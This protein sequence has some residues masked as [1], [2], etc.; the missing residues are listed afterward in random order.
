MDSVNVPWFFTMGV[1]SFG[2]PRIEAYLQLPAAYRSLSR[3]SSAP[4]AKA[5]TLCSCS[6]ELPSFESTF[7]STLFSRSYL[8][9][10]SF[11]KTWILQQKGFPS[12]LFCFAS[13]ISQRWQNCFYPFDWKDLISRSLPK[14]R[15]VF[16]LSI[17]FFILNFSL[18]SI[19]NEHEALASWTPTHILTDVWLSSLSR[20]GVVGASGF[21]PPTSR[22]SV[23]CSSQLSYAPVCFSVT[24]N[25]TTNRVSFAKYDLTL[26]RFLFWSISKLRKSR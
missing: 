26:P 1:P 7:R 19:F 21:E 24:E 13:L 20:L 4:D 23:V 15:F 18:Y 5:F 25:W 17:C 14:T 10:L 22:L 6:L 11:L 9:C 16:V 12:C 8:N 3:P 2:N